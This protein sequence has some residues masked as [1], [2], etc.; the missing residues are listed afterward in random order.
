M[1]AYF[2]KVFQDVDGVRTHR[3]FRIVTGHPMDAV[4]K[5]RMAA[6][7][8]FGMCVVDHEVSLY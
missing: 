3:V 8:Y 7:A 2:V 1:N 4:R 5:A 6:E